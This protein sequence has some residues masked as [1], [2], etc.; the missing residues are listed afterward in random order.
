M[1]KVY[2]LNYHQL[3]RQSYL[4]VKLLLHHHR[5]ALRKSTL[6]FLVKHLYRMLNLVVIGKLLSKKLVIMYS[7]L[8]RKQLYSLYKTCKKIPLY[9]TLDDMADN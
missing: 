9:I 1:V 5:A 7:L 4:Q 6:M 2:R 8:H 3:K